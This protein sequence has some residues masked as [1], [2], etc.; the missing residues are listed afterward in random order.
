MQLIDRHAFRSL[1][2]GVVVDQLVHDR[3]VDVVGPVT[4]SQ[5]CRL[6]P[7]HD[8]VRFDMVEVVQHQ[9]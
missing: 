4:E 1:R 8:P 2:A 7:Q 9:P 6:F 5:L 3:S